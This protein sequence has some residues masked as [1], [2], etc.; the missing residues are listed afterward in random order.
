MPRTTLVPATAAALL[1]LA[2]CG[3]QADETIDA[4]TD[5]NAGS[6]Q[7]DEERVPVEAP[8]ELLDAGGTTVGTAVFTDTDNGAQVQVQINGLPPGFH[9]MHLHDVGT[10]EPDSTAPGG[11]GEPGDFL[12]AGPHLGSATAAHGEHAGDLPSILVTEAGVGEMTTLVGGVDLELLLDG[13]GTALVV[14]ALPDNTGNVPLRYAAEGP[15]ALT[16]ATGDSGDRLL[17]GVVQG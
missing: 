3:G 8:P 10:C 7:P 9:G 17:C 16:L 1:L 14:H 6:D 11:T 12:S 5:Q 13:D 4:G 2:G 15:D